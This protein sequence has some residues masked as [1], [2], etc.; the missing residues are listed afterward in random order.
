MFWFLN[1]KDYVNDIIKVNS[2][3]TE[4][5][6]NITYIQIKVSIKEIEKDLKNTI[7]FKMAVSLLLILNTIYVSQSAMLRFGFVIFV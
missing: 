1:I 6:D 2:L 3:A 5:S 4:D 7:N